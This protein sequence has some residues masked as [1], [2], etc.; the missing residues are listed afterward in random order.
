MKKIYVYLFT[1]FFFLNASAQKYWTGTAGD[2]LWN[3]AGNWTGGTAPI[4]TDDVVINNLNGAAGSFIVTLPNTLVTINSLTITPLGANTIQVHLPAGNTLS[5]G[6]QTTRNIIINNGGSLRNS[7][8][9]AT[10]P[11]ITIGAASTD[12]MYIFNGGTYEHNTQRSI[13]SNAP[14][15]IL[16]KTS[17]AP[18]TEYGRLHFNIPQTGSTAIA[19]QGRTFGSLEFSAGNAPSAL[20]YTSSGTAGTDA[21]I[22]GNLIINS[23]ANF[24]STITGNI[25]LAGNFT[26]TGN[27]SHAP[28]TTGVTG[29]SFIFNG[30]AQVLSGA[31]TYTTGANFRNIEVATGTTLFLQ[32]GI[33]LSNA[34]NGFIVNTGAALYMNTF[35]ISGTG[36]FTT[37]AGSTL[38]IGSPNGITT[39]PTATG[40]V[41][42]AVRNFNLGNYE[43]DGSVAQ[44][45]GTGL[46]ASVKNLVLN[47][48]GGAVVTLTNP[49]NIDDTLS[50]QNGILATA[51]GVAPN[52][53][54]TTAIKSPGNNYGIP[55]IGWESSFVSGPLTK[56]LATTGAQWLPTGNINGAVINFA[57]VQLEKFNSNPTTYT[58]EYIPTAYSD[59][60]VDAGHLQRVSRVEH[61]LISASTAGVDAQS[62]L[63]LSWRPSSQVGDGNP[64][65]DAE[66]LDSLCLARYFD[67]GSGLKWRIEGYINPTNPGFVKTGTVNYGTIASNIYQGFSSPFT[68]GGKSPFNI[69]PLTLLDFS[70][71]LQQN[72]VVLNWVTKEEKGVDRYEAERSANGLQ[73]NKLASVNALNSLDQQQYGTRDY[74]PNA[75]WNYYRLKIFDRI[76]KTSYSGI[77]KVW[78][79]KSTRVLVYPNPAVNELKINLSPTGSIY[80]ISIVNSN[81]QVVH[82]QS[83]KEGML[84]INIASLAKGTYFVKIIDNWQTIVHRFVKH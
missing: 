70:A 7:S 76:G 72:A 16:D 64:A 19:F 66:A 39:A 58:A 67:D 79:G 45:T 80:Q 63:T 81:G 77:V 34:V 75:G 36:S 52:L 29:R 47:N 55:N 30:S 71:G 84:A 23:P 65:H 9:A 24:S 32:H 27:F 37:A 62:K 68:L 22:R 54:D 14:N 50:L 59:L 46:P 6:F 78:V 31:G 49:V 25:R 12:S 43:Y 82:Q 83:T 33:A 18:G 2:G 73:F 56:E 57:P 1:V 15:S 41:T 17:T 40:N 10:V 3:T 5:P 35:A 21:I 61:W 53:R 28:S 11:T 4:S 51:A 20:T 44:V 60:T 13:S 69:L 48:S 8:T 42:T 26:H 38:G 74:S